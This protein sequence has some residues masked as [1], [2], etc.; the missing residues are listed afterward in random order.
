MPISGWLKRILFSLTPLFILIVCS[1]LIFRVTG[2][3]SSPVNSPVLPGE[4]RGLYQHDHELFW[5]MRPG[6]RIPYQGVTIATNELGLRSGPVRPKRS[7]E[8]R[9]LSLGES[10]TFGAG[11]GNDVTYSARLEQI[12]NVWSGQKRFVVIN[13]GGNACPLFGDGFEDGTTAAWS[14]T[15]P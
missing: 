15:V 1:E 8:F 5:S 12:L 13:A 6:V 14:K 11:V 4:A 10:T 7:T 2:L 3:A 9:I